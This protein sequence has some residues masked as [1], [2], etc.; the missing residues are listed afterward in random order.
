MP[1]PKRKSDEQY[2]ARRRA[3]RAIERA[4]NN[5]ASK[6]INNSESIYKEINRLQ[7]LVDKSYYSRDTKKYNYNFANI[8]KQ[9]AKITPNINKLIHSNNT[10]A[11]NNRITKMQQNY[12]RTSG[13]MHK[14]EGARF[15]RYTQSIW[16]GQSPDQRD[17]IIVDYLSNHEAKLNNGMI[18]SN[19]ADAFQFIKEK[20]SEEWAR[21][22]RSNKLARTNREYWSD[23]DEEFMSEYEEES[24]SPPPGSFSN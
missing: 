1:R 7:N 10:Y 9:V 16:E 8:N 22:Q 18:V 11:E 15:Y 17:N 13:A 24:I 23:E 2:N 4:K 6:Q 21:K 12:F 3:R 20:Y 19:L 14:W 5:V